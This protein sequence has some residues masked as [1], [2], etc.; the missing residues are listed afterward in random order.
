M[1]KIRRYG[2]RLECFYFK[3]MFEER[4]VDIQKGTSAMLEAATDVYTSKRFRK[5]L[6][7]ILAVGNYLNSGFR[8]GAY[9][10][11]IDA[12]LKMTET[13]TSLYGGKHTLL[14][15]L[16]EVVE[17]NF[18]DLGKFVDDL[19]HVAQG[20]KVSLPALKT[21]MA[22]L[23][24]SITS[25]RAELEVR[26]DDPI[27]PDDDFMS[28]MKNFYAEA[29]RTAEKLEGEYAKAEAK[30]AELVQL[31]G[32][33]PKAMTPEEFFGIFSRFVNNWV[34]AGEELKEWRAKDLA[35]QSRAKLGPKTRS[36]ENVNAVSAGADG[37]LDDLI[38]VLRT[39][40]AFTEQYESGDAA[41][42][43]EKK[44][45]AKKK[46]VG[47]VAKK[48]NGVELGQLDRSEE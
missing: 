33:D 3:R 43:S 5:M 13:K 19:Q 46:A 26:K 12:I 36:K 35:E 17:K 31:F 7:V 42:A 48:G 32:E 9:G 8:G 16:Y 37:Q 44:K 6:E 45:P 21:E 47:T 10:F 27:Q 25:L 38:S 4:I 2:P 11:K 15:Y 23:R 40:E 41:P 34:V 28:V 29:S 14:H 20:A 1:S 18:K 24:K 39:G 30:F 22:Q